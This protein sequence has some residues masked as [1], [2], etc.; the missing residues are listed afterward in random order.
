[1]PSISN[2]ESEYMSRIDAMTPAQRVA[3]SAAMFAWTREQIAR[4]IADQHAGLDAEALKWRVA[5]RLYQNDP[6][7]CR[8][9][10]R[11]LADVSG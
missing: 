6:A 9:I 8:L 10:E 3:R 1:M 5:L 2:V 11:R 7:I 4:Q